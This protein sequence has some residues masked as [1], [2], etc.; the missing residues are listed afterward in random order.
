MFV[1]V[2]A[3]GGVAEGK[4]GLCKGRRAREGV[5]ER[6]VV[7]ETPPVRKP[8]CVVG[9]ENDVWNSVW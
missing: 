1:V 3:V 6:R 8:H 2:R 4:G 5:G 7:L 9:G